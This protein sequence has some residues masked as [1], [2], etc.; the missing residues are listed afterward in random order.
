MTFVVDDNIADNA[1][2]DMKNGNMDFAALT[3]NTNCEE[4]DYNIEDYNLQD[5][6]LNR[7]DYFVIT[8]VH[9]D[10]LEIAG[11][12]T[13]GV[14]DDTM[15]YLAKKM[16]DDY[17]TQLFWVHLPIFAEYLEIPKKENENEEE[18]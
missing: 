18:K 1:V 16:A 4:S 17:L 13:T 8:R 2:K 9:R 15:K 11:F 10:D 14:S 6:L 7:S 5:V 3:L 12:D